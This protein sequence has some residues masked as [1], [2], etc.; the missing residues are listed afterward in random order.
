MDRKFKRQLIISQIAQLLKQANRLNNK[1]RVLTTQNKVLLH[2]LLE[3]LQEITPS[4]INKKHYRSNNNNSNNNS[5]NNKSPPAK[6]TRSFQNAGGLNSPLQL[7][8]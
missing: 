3:R 8:F 5:N 2:L 7:K 1:N 6:K 4:P